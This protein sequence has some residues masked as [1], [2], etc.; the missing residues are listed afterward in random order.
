VVDNLGQVFIV[1]ACASMFRCFAA[2]T[3]RPIYNSTDP[4]TQV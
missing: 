3:K 4:W 1:I 2:R